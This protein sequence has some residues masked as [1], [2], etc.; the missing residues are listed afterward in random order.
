M[1]LDMPCAGSLTSRQ[2]LAGLLVLLSVI[3]YAIAV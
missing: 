1:L 2:L 3:P